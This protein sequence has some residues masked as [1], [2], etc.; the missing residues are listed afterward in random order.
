MVGPTGRSIWAK[1]LHLQEQHFKDRLISQ[2]GW[3]CA[4]CPQMSNRQ[5]SLRCWVEGIVGAYQ[6]SQ[7]HYGRA[8]VTQLRERPFFLS[9]LSRPTSEFGIWGCGEIGEV[10][11]DSSPKARGPGVPFAQKALFPNR[12]ELGLWKWWEGQPGLTCRLSWKQFW[13]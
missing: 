4:V 7:V 2:G 13:L 8:P 3:C 10:D 9:E 1:L 11:F 5:L 6:R 12:A